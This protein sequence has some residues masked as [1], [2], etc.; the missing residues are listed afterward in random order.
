MTTR[1]RFLEFV[2]TPS[3]ESSAKRLLS[4]EDQRALELLLVA[5]PSEAE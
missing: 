3:F 1:E 4:V 5:D 2:G